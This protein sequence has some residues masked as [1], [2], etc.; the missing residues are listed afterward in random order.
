MT[1]KNMIRYGRLT[2]AQKMTRSPD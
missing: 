1:A 2:R